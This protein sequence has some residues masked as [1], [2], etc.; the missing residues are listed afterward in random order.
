MKEI[1]QISKIILF[2]LILGRPALAMDAFEYQ[3]YDGEINKVSEYSLETHLN[4]N[5]RGKLVADYPGQLNENHLTH[6]TFEFARG[7]TSY[8]ELG[9]YLQSALAEDGT[10]HYAGAKIRSKFVRPTSE[11]DPLQI[12][13]NF[14]ISNV[15]LEF[16]QDRWGSEIRPIIGYTIARWTFLFNP[17]IDIDITPGKDATPDFAPALKTVFD[18]RM[19]FGLGLEYYSELGDIDK[20]TGFDRADQY[21]FAAYDLL[22]ANFELNLGL[23]FGLTDLSNPLVAKGILGFTF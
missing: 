13:I 16:E 22:H 7:M 4:S 12:G 21:L 19:G 8:W 11:N 15:P 2:L 14:E 3:V 5:L 23:G 18:T 10:G 1:R 20:A 6:L 17:I 9:G